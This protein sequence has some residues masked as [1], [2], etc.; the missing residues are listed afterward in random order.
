MKIA[1]WQ[2][3]EHE[4]LHNFGAFIIVSV[5][6]RSGC[7]GGWHFNVVS[8]FVRL[9][10]AYEGIPVGI[11]SPV[12]SVVQLT[13]HSL[14]LQLAGTIASTRDVISACEENEAD[15]AESLTHI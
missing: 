15:N 8:T 7:G 1:R 9:A 3:S 11:A 6:D 2:A 4:Y 5:K 12:A 10:A 13:H 14:E